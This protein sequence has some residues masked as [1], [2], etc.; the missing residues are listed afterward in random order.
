MVETEERGRGN[1][2][3][4]CVITCECVI[5]QVCLQGRDAEQEDSRIPQ[6]GGRDGGREGGNI[7]QTHRNNTGETT[8]SQQNRNSIDI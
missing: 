4:F 7:R 3:I 2:V 6:E 1:R 5:E 8:F